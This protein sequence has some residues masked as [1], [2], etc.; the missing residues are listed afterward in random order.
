MKY[1]LNFNISISKH[2]YNKIQ[3]YIH[4]RER[5]ENNLYFSIYIYRGKYERFKGTQR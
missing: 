3:K 4:K 5:D 2:I 1:A